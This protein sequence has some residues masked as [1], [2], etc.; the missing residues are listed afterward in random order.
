M[1]PP[2][3]GVFDLDHVL[4]R[5]PLGDAHDQGHLCLHGLHNGGGGAG[6]RHVDY[7]GVRLGVRKG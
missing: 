2:E 1:R 4:L 3:E 7:C 6:G 5:D